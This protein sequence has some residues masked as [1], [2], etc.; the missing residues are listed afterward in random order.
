MNMKRSL[1]ILLA[2]MMCLTM[3]ACG[4]KEPE[5]VDDP[6]S[7]YD[8]AGRLAGGEAVSGANAKT[9][10]I[11]ESGDDIS[12][13][14][15]FII[16]SRRS[17]SEV[18]SA[19]DAVP[20]Y[21]VYTLDSPARL[22]VEFDALSY[23]DF[24]RSLDL[25]SALFFGMFR[26]SL[27]NSENVAFYFQLNRPVQ[28]MVEA[29]A[30]TL[31]VSLHPYER[32][33]EPAASADASGEEAG[34]PYS[35][36]VLSNEYMDYCN[37]VISR[38]IDMHPVLASDFSTVLLISDPFATQ[39]EAEQFR[40]QTL[41][42]TDGAAAEQW[43]VIALYDDDLP[44][45][46][47]TLNYAATYSE[48][49]I[50]EDGAETTPEVLIP[51]GRYLAATPSG[52]RLF[53]RRQASGVVGEMDYYYEELWVMDAEGEARRMVNYEFA[54]IEKAAYSTDGHKLA[55]L[56]RAEESSHLYVFSVDTAELL[57][58]LSELGFGS[59]VSNFVW[60]N[61]SSVIY[62]LSGSGELELHMYDFTV[63]DDSERHSLVSDKGADE[64]SL[65]IMNGELI[66][67]LTD[68][69]GN[70]S[71]YLI[72]PQGGVPR[73]FI[74]GGS[75]ALSRSGL[76]L[77]VFDP[78]DMTDD[79]RV[80]SDALVLYSF[81]T[82]GTSV[83]TDDFSVYDFVW[84][85]SGSKLYYVESLQENLGG[86]GLGDAGDDGGTGGGTDTP[87]AAV[88]EDP[89]NYALWVYDV[90]TGA[91]ERL[92]EFKAGYFLPGEDDSVMYFI[93]SDADTLGA[94]V[95]ATYIV[96]FD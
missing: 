89:Y 58:D 38:E 42:L 35:Y 19:A 53:T 2:I 62:G 95:S 15:T 82:G 93:Y 37:G 90:A 72:K 91:S 34:E 3:V 28:Y 11:T 40:V 24:T 23:W 49:V 65:A 92:F 1:S 64:G 50:R 8:T 36:Y 33:Y 75:F 32:V 12:L 79:G 29:T 48:L 27:F 57:V 67:A 9:L 66:Y 68:A 70:P 5:A 21:S 74:G 31:T 47:A 96:T 87:A 94:R 76:Y 26:Q 83:I 39:L 13:M 85:R 43:S 14:F 4:G 45:Y 69:D 16:G 59:Q 20:S 7:G 51:F 17:G 73:K 41:A 46:D 52:G 44:D 60:D 56:E 6:Y 88:D 71:L 25:P 61:F 63:L 18:E 10:E 78:A 55:V 30:D 77:A 86:E 81:E 84:N 54:T 80:G 22:V